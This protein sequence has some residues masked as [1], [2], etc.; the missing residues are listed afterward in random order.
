MTHVRQQIR[1]NVAFALIAGATDAGADVFDSVVFPKES[2]DLPLLHVRADTE[3][4]EAVQMGGGIN[5]QRTLEITITAIAQE[6][7]DRDLA[8]ALDRL[9]AQ[10]EAIIGNDDLGG[11][12]KYNQLTGSEISRDGAG[13]RAT[14]Q[15][16]LTFTAVYITSGSDGETAL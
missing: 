10:V 2:D 11:L 16:Q 7:D 8:N 9:A 5:L 14:G 3:E 6:T 4:S 1:E 15:I 13:S 12:V